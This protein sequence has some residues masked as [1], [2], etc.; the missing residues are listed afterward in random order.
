MQVM[1]ILSPSEAALLGTNKPVRTIKINLEQKLKARKLKD[2]K[3]A[4]GHQS[5][6][7]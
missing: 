6:A 2:E 4:D 7:Q 1:I 3:S 5:V